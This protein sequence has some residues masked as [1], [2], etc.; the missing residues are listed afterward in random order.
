MDWDK[1]PSETL[2]RAIDVYL[3]LAYPGG[4]AP[5]TAVRKRL[6][7]LR[8]T[9]PEALYESAVFERTPPAPQEATRLA[10][11]LGCQFYPHMKLAVERAPDGRTPLLKADTHD[12]HIQVKPGSPDYEAF[13]ELVRKN[14]ALAAEIEAAW[15]QAGLPTFKHFLREDLARRRMGQAASPGTP[16]PAEGG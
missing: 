3:G 8:A 10:L 14:Q 1:P 2:W 13:A 11:R 6:D 4:G 5:P 7:T 15:E 12:R 16:A 9:P